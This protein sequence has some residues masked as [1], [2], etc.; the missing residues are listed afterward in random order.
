ML[1][2]ETKIKEHHLDLTI[3]IEKH[4]LKFKGSI[5]KTEYVYEET[6][7]LISYKKGRKTLEKSYT[8]ITSK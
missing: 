2:I 3:Q 1:H 5:S 8:L 4:F 6:N 7:T